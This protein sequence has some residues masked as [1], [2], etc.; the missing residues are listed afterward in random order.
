[1]LW[2]FTVAQLTAKLKA[3]RAAGVAVRCVSGSKAELVEHVKIC[4]HASAQAVGPAAAA[5]AGP[6]AAVLPLLAPLWV[7]ALDLLEVAL[8]A[9]RM[10]RTVNGTRRT[11]YRTWTTIAWTR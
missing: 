8:V 2:N 10:T 5:A 4:M 11:I 1:M 7:L 3:F 9:W 6:P